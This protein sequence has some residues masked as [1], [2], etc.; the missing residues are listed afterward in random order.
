MSEE[1]SMTYAEG[2]MWEGSRWRMVFNVKCDG[3]GTRNG[4]CRHCHSIREVEHTNQYGGKWTEREWICPRVVE[5][6]NEGGCASTGV[7]AD[8]IHEAVMVIDGRM[9]NEVVVTW[10][11]GGE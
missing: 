1:S 3:D 10:N 6:D 8:C 7:C 5:A 4:P 11:G 2:G 9:A